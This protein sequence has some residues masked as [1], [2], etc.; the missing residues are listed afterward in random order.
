MIHCG[1]LCLNKYAV[2]CLKESANNYFRSVA[3]FVPV[4]CELSCKYFQMQ[5]WWDC[6]HV[7]YTGISMKALLRL[8][9]I[10]HS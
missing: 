1:G 5:P 3:P 7:F 8:K 2:F 4:H 10:I 9:G 6:I